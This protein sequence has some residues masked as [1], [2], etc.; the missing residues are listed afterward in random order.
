MNQDTT[1]GLGHMRLPGIA[2]SS[3]QI[4]RGLGASGANPKGQVQAYGVC[5]CQ[6][7][8]AKWT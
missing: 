6:L 8:G 7:W 3:R 2:G 1:D 5:V 4:H